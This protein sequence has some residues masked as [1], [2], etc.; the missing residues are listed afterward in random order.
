MT[1]FGLV[2]ALCQSSRVIGIHRRHL[3]WN[4]PDDRRDFVRLTRDKILI[5]GRHTWQERAVVGAGKN[6]RVQEE[7]DHNNN[8]DDDDDDDDSHIRHARQTVVVSRTLTPRQVQ[9]RPGSVLARS[10]PEALAMARQLA[11]A[12]VTT[13]GGVPS[14][15]EQPDNADS[16]MIPNDQIPCWIA[17][18]QAIYQEAILHPA[19]ERLV[20]TEMDVELV[21]LDHPSVRDIARFP[22]PSL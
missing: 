12:D 3:P 1:K 11:M 15:N 10:L 2:A 22:H 6:K 4:V 18:G 7:D 8:N 13:S 14:D 21:D 17:G 19:V 9:M 5:V 20:L 16:S